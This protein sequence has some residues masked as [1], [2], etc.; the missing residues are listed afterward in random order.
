MRAQERTSILECA[1][2][3]NCSVPSSL[4]DQAWILS[5]PGWGEMT[6]GEQ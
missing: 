5:R 3:K 6:M 2:K 1:N 4:H